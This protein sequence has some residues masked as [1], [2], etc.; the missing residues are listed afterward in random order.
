MVFLYCIFSRIFSLV[1]KYDKC[2]LKWLSVKKKKLKSLVLQDFF[3]AMLQ[4]SIISWSENLISPV[5][6]SLPTNESIISSLQN[7][8]KYCTHPK[9]KMIDMCVKASI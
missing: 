9:P 2:L 5:W 3:Q 7:V 8:S 4:S 1:K 6:S